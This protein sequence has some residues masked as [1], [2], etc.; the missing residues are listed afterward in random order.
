MG[1]EVLRISAAAGNGGEILNALAGL[2]FEV[3]NSLT[4]LRFQSLNAVGFGHCFIKIGS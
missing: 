1:F 2:A 3:L 4:G